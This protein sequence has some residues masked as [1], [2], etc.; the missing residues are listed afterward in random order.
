MYN[1]NQVAIVTRYITKKSILEANK[2]LKWLSKLLV[3]IDKKTFSYYLEL[4]WE[5]Y[6]IFLNEK[7]LLS[8]WKMNFV[9]KKN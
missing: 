4:Y 7:A 2:V 6:K 1:F 5:V 9:H 3:R 8:N